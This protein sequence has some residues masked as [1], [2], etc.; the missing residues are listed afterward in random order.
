MESTDGDCEIL[1]MFPGSASY[2]PPYWSHRTMNVGNELL[3]FYCIYPADAG[4]DYAT[5]EEQGYP[6]LVVEIDG[7]VAIIDNPKRKNK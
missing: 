7:K 4:H 2:I 5:I 3:V 6:K 1:E